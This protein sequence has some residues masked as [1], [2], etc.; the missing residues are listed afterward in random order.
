MLFFKLAKI[1][2]VKNSVNFTYFPGDCPRGGDAATAGL[3][4]ARGA[5]VRDLCAPPQPRAICD[6]LQRR[7]A[8][9]LRHEAGQHLPLSYPA[10]LAQLG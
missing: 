5:G 4:P 9:P 2:C 1:F 3:L 10:T 8:S 7:Q 6:G